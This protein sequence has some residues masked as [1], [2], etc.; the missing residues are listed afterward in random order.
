[1]TSY[2]DDVRHRSSSVLVRRLLRFVLSSITITAAAAAAVSAGVI[3]TAGVAVVSTDDLVRDARCLA[4]CYRQ[5][6]SEKPKC[7][8]GCMDERWIKPGECPVGDDDVVSLDRP[9][10]EQC[11]SDD[12]CHSEYKCCRHSCGVTC[13]P[14]VGLADSP[15]L[16]N[17][18]R[19]IAVSDSG[20]ALAVEWT[21]PTSGVAA[22]GHVTYV[23][24]ERH[25]VG[26]EYVP[27]RMTVWTTVIRTDRTREHLRQLYAP[28]RWFQ[29]R[30]AAINEN[31]TRGY[32]APSKQFFVHIEP[33]I[34]PPGLPENLTVSSLKWSAGGKYQQCLLSWSP[35]DFS[36]IPVRKYK[37]FIS[38]RDGPHVYQRRHIVP[39]DILS[40][41]I[42]K[43]NANTEYFLQVQ[44]IS[45]F[46]R[47]RLT[48]R[49]ASTTLKTKGKKLLNSKKIKEL[50]LVNIKNIDNLNSDLVNVRISWSPVVRP[51]LLSKKI[52]YT[53]S[54]S[55][56][57]CDD[58][59]KA[60]RA[61]TKMA[62]FDLLSLNP[63][64]KYLIVVST[65][66]NGS[67]YVGSFTFDTPTL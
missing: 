35:P 45:E 33:H 48:G 15:G 50:K 62:Y 1:M 40:F 17:V 12:S 64:C 38:V 19:V 47:K 2:C 9:C 65:K 53:L 37:V 21:Q 46:G 59:S 13:Q 5:I 34:N 44:A 60:L 61:K 51:L 16:P 4:K 11:A 25:H 39:A 26:A 31:G 56:K 43:L 29:F 24:Q 6:S 36:V 63:Q 41:P 27:E 14:P 49:K 58:K 57:D 3:A 23:L 30:V 66:L 20:K 22:A 42:K 54:W 7:Y 10:L 8:S 52:V 67:K 32:S 28:G 18:P 55:P